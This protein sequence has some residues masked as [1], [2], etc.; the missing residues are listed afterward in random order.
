MDYCLSVRPAGAV[1]FDI[2]NKESTAV[3]FPLLHE[4]GEGQGGGP[5]SSSFPMSEL[6]WT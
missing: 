1:L 4:V 5:Q 3:S 6:R 2:V